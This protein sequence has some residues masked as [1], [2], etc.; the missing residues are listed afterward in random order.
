MS[1]LARHRPF[2]AAPLL[3]AA[4]L[5][6]CEGDL[7]T[8]YALPDATATAADD[9]QVSGG[10]AAADVPTSDVSPA[11]VALP[12]IQAPDVQ[13]PD[14][15]LPDVTLPEVPKP[16]VV[17]VDVPK[18]DTAL[19]DVPPPDVS[20]PDVPAPDVQAPDV[21]T[22]DVPVVDVPA[23]DVACDPGPCNDGNS[24]T[25]DTCT[26]G[27][28]CVHTPAT[29]PCNDGNACTDGDTCNGT[30]CIGA[31]NCVCATA[32]GQP[33]PALDDCNTPDD[34]NCNGAI[35]EAGTCGLTTYAF[36]APPECGFTCYYD[37]PHDLTVSGSA[38][39][40]SGF[41]TFAP[42]Q[43]MDGKKGGNDWYAELGNGPAYEWVGWKQATAVVTFQFP[44]PRLVAKVRVGLNNFVQGVVVEPPEVHVRT[45]QDA[46]TWS[47]PVVFA[48][49]AGT[50]PAIVAG[51]RGDVVLPTPVT[52]ARYVEVSFLSPGSWTFV[53]EIAF[54]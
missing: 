34:D 22:P 18:P 3:I 21:Q 31:I 47:A 16:D 52:I 39:N 30:T 25:T 20:L 36:S 23:P 44:Q 26:N 28:G 9:A 54:D 35:N 37:E 50:L 46:V 19:P 17:Q 11:D 45:S 14:V 33:L 43:L 53:D 49:D 27:G 15:T 6:G 48:L 2:F 51:Q 12:D 13:A 4:L 38:S 7:D 1:H 5:A 10:D 29:G 8:A 32:N 40:T 42:G 24:C 41:A